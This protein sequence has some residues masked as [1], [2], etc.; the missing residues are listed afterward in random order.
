MTISDEKTLLL[1]K[2]DC[3]NR[4]LVGECI[5]RFEEHGF[6]IRGLKMLRATEEQMR[7]H[8]GGGEEW[9][10]SLGQRTL[11]DLARYG[12]DPMQEV[13]ST[14][15][16]VVGKIV[17]EWLISYMLTTP[18][19]AMV[20]SGPNAVEM[21]RKIVGNTIPQ[22]ADVG[23]IRGDFSIDSPMLATL[24]K[25]AIKN[26]IH[27]SGNRE[28]AEAEVSHWFTPEELY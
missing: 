14:D 9:V 11:D 3:L 20:V 23:S 16:L 10:R 18:L 2:A 21:G 24:E 6:K 26:L 27:A 8:Y 5:K 12:K 28:E 1:F 25:R 15:T 4:G 13:G 22:K 17:L 19:I 7:K